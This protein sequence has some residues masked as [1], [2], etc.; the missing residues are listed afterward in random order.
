MEALD[1]VIGVL[2]LII[3]AAIGVTLARRAGQSSEHYF[4]GGRAMPWWALGASGM[5]RNLDVAGTMTIVALIY[6]YGLHGFFI[7]L[8][9]G[10]VLPIAIFLAFMGKWHR[11]SAVMTTPPNGCCCDLATGLRVG[12]RELGWR[13]L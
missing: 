8:R 11:R 13:G 4:L 9:G 10:V 7:E 5:A 1:Y 3:L 12:P 6:L 2:Y